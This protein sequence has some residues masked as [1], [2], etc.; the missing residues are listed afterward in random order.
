VQESK[1]R[2]GSEKKTTT[3]SVLC[4]KWPNSQ[5][6]LPRKTAEGG[7]LASQFVG[8]HLFHGKR[9]GGIE[10]E[11]RGQPRLERKRGEPARGRRC[12]HLFNAWGFVLCL[13]LKGG[14]KGNA[15][16][17]AAER[18]RLRVRGKD[19]GCTIYGVSPTKACG[20]VYV[21]KGGGGGD[22]GKLRKGP[23]G[24]AERRQVL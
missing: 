14:K 18:R 13:V 2:E 10:R 8:Q 4:L 22:L 15:T 12:Q 9:R 24:G 5:V 23:G 7:H 17:P 20:I 21:V 19:P 3:E 16:L 11:K 6:L 1:T